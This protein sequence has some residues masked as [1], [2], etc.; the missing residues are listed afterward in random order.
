MAVF[1]LGGCGGSKKTD[2]EEVKTS[3]VTKS[4]IGAIKAEENNVIAL[5]DKEITIPSDYRVSVLNDEQTEITTYFVFNPEKA[6]A[7]ADERDG[8]SGKDYENALREA[9]DKAQ[10]EIAEQAKKSNIFKKDE[11]V[12]VY[13]P[14]AFVF[15]TDAYTTAYHENTMMYIYSGVD[16]ATPAE[17]L[18]DYQIIA[19]CKAYLTNSLGANVQLRNIIWDTTNVPQITENIMF[20]EI[21]DMSLNGDY[22]VLTFTANAGNDETATYGDIVYAQQYYGIFLMEKDVWDGSFRNWYG[23]VFKNDGA[24]D[25]MDEVAYNDIMGQIKTEMGVTQYYTTILDTTAWNYDETQDFRNGRTYDQLNQ[26]FY[27]TRNFYVITKNKTVDLNADEA[28]T[29]T[30]AP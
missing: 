3:R 13:E 10:Q 27:N 19:S 7:I 16:R 12:E 26:L 21:N 1:V 2:P 29:S 30:T 20:P 4:T 24:G 25:V 15:D 9:W 18:K 8:R 5:G 17:G 11:D 28:E 6:N 22:F 14:V 23:F